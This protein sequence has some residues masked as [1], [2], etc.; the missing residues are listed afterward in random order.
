MAMLIGDNA[1]VI[2]IDRTDYPLQRSFATVSTAMAQNP[3]CLLRFTAL[4]SDYG[5]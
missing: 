1:K 3:R 4:I 5:C 2:T